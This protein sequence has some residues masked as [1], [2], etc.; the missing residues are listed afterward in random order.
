MHRLRGAD[1]GVERRPSDALLRLPPRARRSPALRDGHPALAEFMRRT[2]T[3][4]RTCIDCGASFEGRADRCLG[5]RAARI[6]GGGELSCPVRYC[7]GCGVVL[8]PRPLK[9][10]GHYRVCSSCRN[11]ELWDQAIPYLERG[12]VMRAR[13]RR[14]FTV[15]EIEESLHGIRPA[16]MPRAP[17]R[18]LPTCARPGCFRVKVY[19]SHLCYEC[20]VQSMLEAEAE[21]IG[22]DLRPPPPPAH[23]AMPLVLARGQWIQGRPPFDWF[24]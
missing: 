14:L 23:P 1:H 12:I 9:K 4:P 22:R 19:A 18:D 15:P 6:Y 11:L 17:A 21:E 16:R 7:R 2:L 8:G 10:G 20:D 13:W 5:C 3:R 24:S